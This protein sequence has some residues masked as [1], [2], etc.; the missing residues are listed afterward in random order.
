MA[1]LSWGGL[2]WGSTWE[3]CPPA[4]EG[5]LPLP[6]SSS[7]APAFLDAPGWGSARQWGPSGGPAVQGGAAKPKFGPGVWAGCMLTLGWTLA[8]GSRRDL[9]GEPL[10]PGSPWGPMSVLSSLRDVRV[11]SAVSTEG[12]AP[13]ARVP[14][15]GDACGTPHGASER[16]LGTGGRM[17][18]CLARAA[19]GL[20]LLEARGAAEQGARRG[21]HGQRRRALPRR[22]CGAGAGALM[23]GGGAGVG[24]SQAAEP[25]RVRSVSFCVWAVPRLLPSTLAQGA[26]ACPV[27][28]CGWA[29]RPDAPAT[30]KAREGQQV[31]SGTERPGVQ[32]EGPGLSE[33]VMVLAK[34]DGFPPE[35]QES[36]G[37]EVSGARLAGRGPCSCHRAFQARSSQHFTRPGGQRP[38]GPWPKPGPAE[39]WGQ[40][41]AG[42][43]PSG[44]GEAPFL[45]RVTSEACSVPSSCPGLTVE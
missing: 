28:W 45:E 34:G 32:Q 18:S 13:G 7:E 9:T 3:G 14:R 31:L 23:A 8:G 44:S 20:W 33:G 41:S 19:G 11:S 1:S 26:A 6:G 36:G 40:L 17:A 21:Q 38:Q 12:F 30:V 15:A 25:Q 4:G 37:L 35:A 39:L 10:L 2:G 42:S 24:W 27:C 16:P 22:V 43:W 5:C 29:T